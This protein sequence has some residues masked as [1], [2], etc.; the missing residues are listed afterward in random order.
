[1]TAAS[2]PARAPFHILTMPVGPICNLDCSY[3]YYLEK[4]E[5]Y[6]GNRHWAMEEGVLERFVRQYIDAQPPDTPEVIFSWQGGEP[7]LLPIS[8]YARAVELQQ[9]HTRTGM[10]CRNTI[11]TNG[12]CLDD[13][14]CAFL[15]QHGFL[16]GLSL[17]G[18]AEL[19]D[20]YRLDRQGLPTHHLVMRALANLQKHEVEYNVLTVIHRLNADHPLE[21]YRFLRGRGV[22]FMQFIP[23]VEKRPGIVSGMLST[24]NTVAEPA[25]LVSDRSVLPAQFGQFMISVFDEWHAHDVGRVFVQTFDEALAAWTGHEPGLCIFRETCGR[26]LALEHNGDVYSCDHF[27][28]A[29]HRL[30]SICEGTLPAMVDSTAQKAFGMAKRDALPAHCRRCEVRFACNGECPKNRILVSPDGE[31][32]LNYLCEGYRRFFGHI[33]PAMKRMAEALWRAM[34][35]SPASAS[36]ADEQSVH[37][38]RSSHPPGP[39]R[40]DPCPCGSGRKYKKC[41]LSGKKGMVT[42]LLLFVALLIGILA[43]PVRAEDELPAPRYP[44]KTS[45]TLLTD[46]RIEEARRRIDTDASAAKV[47]DAVLAEAEFWTRRSDDEARSLIPPA[48]VPRSYSVGNAGCPACGERIYERGTY[49]WIL[50]PEHPYQVKCPIDGKVYPGNDFAAS[51]AADFKDRNREGMSHYDDGWGWYDAKGNRYWFI[52]YGCNWQWSSKILPG[53]RDLGR[54]YTLTG[55]QKY[56]HKAAVILV[57]IAKRYPSMHYRTQSRRGVEFKDPY[58]WGRILNYVSETRTLSWLAEA[59]DAVWERIDSDAQLQAEFGLSGEQLRGLIEANLLE[60]GMEAVWENDILGNYGMHQSAYALAAICRQN[61]PRDTWLRQIIDPDRVPHN[62]HE[63][64]KYALF[65]AVFRDGFPTEVSPAYNVIWPQEIIPVAELL[66]REGMLPEDL[67]R[68]LAALSSVPLRIAM[69]NQFTPDQG[70]SG[71]PYGGLVGPNARTS[72]IT[73]SMFHQ[74][75]MRAWIHRNRYLEAY[76]DYESLFQDAFVPS[77]SGDT[78]PPVPRARLLDGYGMG[79]LENSDHTW[80][81]SMYFGH[82][83]GHSH[84]DPLNF[85]LFAFGQKMMP[86]LGYPDQSDGYTPGRMSW[87]SNTIAHNTVMVDRRQAHEFGPAQVMRYLDSDPLRLIDADGGPSFYPQTHTYRR[88]LLMVETEGGPGYLVDLFRVSGGDEHHYS[89]HGPSGEV[90]DEAGEWSEP[91]PGTLA[92]EHVAVGEMYDR[93]VMMQ[94]DYK[95]TFYDYYG[96]GFSHFVNCRR[97]LAGEPVIGFRH[98]R[99][100]RVRLQIRFHPQADDEV[101]SAEAQTS[102]L[103]YKEMLRYLLAHRMRKTDDPLQSTFVAV[104]EPSKDAMMVVG[105]SCERT[106]AGIIL[107]VRRPPLRDVIYY[108]L[109]EGAWPEHGNIRTD[110]DVLLVTLDERGAVRRWVRSGGSFAEKNNCSLEGSAPVTCQLPPLTGRVV[111]VAPE[112]ARVIIQFDSPVSAESL[113]GRSL[114]FQQGGR[115]NRHTVTA[116]GQVTGGVAIVVDDDLRIGRGKVLR[117]ERDRVITRTKLG[118]VPGIFPGSRLCDAACRRFVPVVSVSPAKGREG[119]FIDEGIITLG[120]SLPEGMCKPDDGFWLCTFGPG[121]EVRAEGVDMGEASD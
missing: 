46:A 119:Q 73:A 116:A 66:E 5:L 62:L 84:R 106:D 11:Q 48:S 83:D 107:D 43:Q 20:P 105:S 4:A 27:V 57:E 100:D 12:V 54:A 97:L 76:P 6:P 55:D 33:A 42:G 74:P 60:E 9:H 108:R 35:S 29:D 92:G 34:P 31:P 81:V 103:R 2:Q 21:V 65:N 1:M 98:A 95:G 82:V 59:Y 47:R 44:L 94:E 25:S 37:R 78:S 71:S 56:A 110:A 39:S 51:L 93:P 17:D 121:A 117:I 113:V 13:N 68:K 77:P 102:P 32:G 104:M 19:H 70:D 87:T 75:I 38:R 14:W 28:T 61:G 10:V 63:G 18:P 109:S 101:I 88:A 72:V 114:A 8:F 7:T 49:P 85:D 30:G 23:L 64:F 89:L 96:S 67:K 26:A 53:V 99:D 52:A 16:V 50:D 22:R 79:L 91:A 58:A 36:P 120:E 86:D 69:L 45:R 41:C 3:C 111:E 80:G 112:E 15:R 24:A 118:M 40:N 115:T 90:T